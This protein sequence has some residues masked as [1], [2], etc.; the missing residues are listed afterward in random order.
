MML[1]VQFMGQ[2]WGMIYYR[3]FTPKENQEDAP[4]PTPLFP[5]PNIIQLI[6]FGFIFITTDTWVIGGHVPL[7]EIS[8]LFLLTGCGMYLLWARSKHFWPYADD[9]EK[10][11]DVDDTVYHVTVAKSSTSI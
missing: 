6:I 5:I 9:I 3:Y 8:L 7:L 2:S 1:F 10:I 4:F 11:G